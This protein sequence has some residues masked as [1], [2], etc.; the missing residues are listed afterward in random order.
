VRF[1]MICALVRLRL[2]GCLNRSFFA[3]DSF[4][5]FFLLSYDWFLIWV[6]LYFLHVARI[7]SF[8]SCCWLISF[9]MVNIWEMNR[10]SFSFFFLLMFYDL[11]FLRNLLDL[12][13]TNTIL[14][15]FY[16]LNFSYT[17]IFFFIRLLMLKMGR[18]R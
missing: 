16:S 4:I 15:L 12:L 11:R 17:S 2:G 13:E 7:I 18:K 6:S 3:I 1:L 5:F 10:V 9:A 14:F 8:W